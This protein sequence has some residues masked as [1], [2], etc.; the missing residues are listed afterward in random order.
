[1]AR[2]GCTEWRARLSNQVGQSVA[3]RK[4]VPTMPG[5]ARF[6]RSEE[7]S[8]PRKTAN[9]TVTMYFIA[10]DGGEPVQKRFS[11]FDALRGR[12]IASKFPGAKDARLPGKM[13]KNVAKRSR[14][15]PAFLD[16]LLDAAGDGLE[17]D[18]SAAPL[19]E[20]L[21][22][23]A[24]AALLPEP[25]PEPEPELVLPGPEPELDIEPEPEPE[26]TYHRLERTVSPHPQPAPAPEAAA[27]V[28][29]ASEPDW[30]AG[31]KT[32]L[33]RPFV[34]KEITWARTFG[35]SVITIFEDESRRQG[36]FDYGAPADWSPHCLMC[37]VLLCLLVVVCVCV[38][39]C[40]CVS[41][42]CVRCGCLGVFLLWMCVRTVCEHFE[43]V[44]G[45]ISPFEYLMP[46]SLALLYQ[47]KPGASTRRRPCAKPLFLQHLPRVYS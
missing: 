36:H 30:S 6:V 29:P 42:V 33:D 17:T 13:K 37:C 32:C 3:G 38:C 43:T 41:G 27:L 46:L 4:Q 16:A 35:R 40:V 39:V 12:L 22:G 44:L 8:D 20:F 19:R 5:R 18:P 47:A 14:A 25:E 31:Y 23:G 26:Q 1:M 21:D 24:E 15:L 28:S 11:E 2:R 9:R 34:R 10:V 7:Q 45:R